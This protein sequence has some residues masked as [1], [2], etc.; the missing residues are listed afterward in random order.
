MAYRVASKL[1]F[2]A[3]WANMKEDERL[4]E[5]VAALEVVAKYGGTIESQHVLWSDGVLLSIASYPD[6]A[7]SVKSEMAI[8][9][10]GAFVLQSQPAFTLDEIVGWQGEVATS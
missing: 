9:A 4:S 5:Q 3:A 2:S 10:R 1:T 8:T 7:S 6:Q